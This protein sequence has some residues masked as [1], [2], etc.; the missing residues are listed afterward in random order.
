MVRF[1]TIWK[2]VKIFMAIQIFNAVMDY[3]VWV[4]YGF[5]VPSWTIAT[6]NLIY[7]PL[8]LGL[9]IAQQKEKAKLK[10]QK[11]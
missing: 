5:L 7:V 10:L 1:E 11:I 3:Y 4:A 9:K 2:I 8:I 6:L